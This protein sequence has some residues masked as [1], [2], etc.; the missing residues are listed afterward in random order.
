MEAL[1]LWALYVYDFLEYAVPLALLPVLA[2]RHR[3]QVALSWLLAVVLLP[4]L[5]A[6]AYL[7]LGTYRRRRAGRR[8]R[9]MRAVLHGPMDPRKRPTGAPVERDPEG[10]MVL[11]ERAGADHLGGWRALGGNRVELVPDARV[12]VD[13]LIEDIESARHSVHLLF[14]LF[15]A[16]ARGWRVGDALASAAHRG[17]PCRLLAGSYSSRF[18]GETSL[19]GP[20]AA[21]LESAGVE[22]VP[23]EP[24]SPLRGRLARTDL[25]N[26]RKLAVI[27][28]DAGWIGSQNIHGPEDDARGGFRE[29]VARVEGPAAAQLQ[30]VFAEDW[31]RNAGRVLEDPELFAGG[32]A[33]G[34]TVVQPVWWGPTDRR[35]ASLS[36]VVGPIHSARE[37][38][39]LATAY[40]V[41]DPAVLLALRVAA[42]RGVDVDV[43]FPLRSDKRLVDA[44]S[45]SYFEE[46]LAAGV[47][48][49]RHG[50]GVLH[51]KCLAVDDRLAMVGSANLDNRSL[52]L[53]FE[54]NVFLHDAELARRVH[55]VVAG[56][57]KDAATV[58]P[59]AWRGR[60][61]PS[62]TRD[63]VAGLLAPVL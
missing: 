45:R 58:D 22:V 35:V 28:G 25:R 21:S 40:F 4:V 59:K 62:R 20:L 7:L 18:E 14:Y 53:D 6:A 3:P 43:I 42:E 34:G 30:G 13:R 24:L 10:L 19:F 8:E 36:A 63:A 27:D 41:P 37:R 48:L 51:T 33:R 57:R 5:G 39:S 55:D 26:H 31:Y 54:A 49:H 56:Y 23:L 15:D 50:E 61:L 44:A 2:L 29:L 12:A 11:L 16:G 60:S 17:V 52:Y 9:E 38:I 1:P 32:E 46:L 47:R